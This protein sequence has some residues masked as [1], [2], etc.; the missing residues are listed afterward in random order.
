MPE[1]NREGGEESE[2]GWHFGWLSEQGSG[3]C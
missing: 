2:G 1:F 3:I